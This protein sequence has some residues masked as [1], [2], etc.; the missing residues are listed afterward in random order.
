MKEA[1]ANVEAEHAALKSEHAALKDSHETAIIKLGSETL[2]KL[3]TIH[4]AVTEISEV[5]YG[6]VLPFSLPLGAF[7][8]VQY[9]PAFALLSTS[10]LDSLREYRAH[11]HQRAVRLPSL[12]PLRHTPHFLRVSVFQTFSWAPFL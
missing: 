7:L 1:L 2:A 4:I 6:T 5:Q 11:L 12:L 10:R 8:H 9:C 3:T